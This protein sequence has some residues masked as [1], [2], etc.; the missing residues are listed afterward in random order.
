MYAEF[1]SI[2]TH[3]LEVV[4]AEEDQDLSLRKWSEDIEALTG[5]KRDKEVRPAFAVLTA[6]LQ[7][8]V[9]TSI[10]SRD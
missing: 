1:S 4:V 5:L 2:P 6:S 9:A 8:R 10:E 7:M 3:D